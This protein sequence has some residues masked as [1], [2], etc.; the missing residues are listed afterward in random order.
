M[1]CQCKTDKQRSRCV[2]WC[3]PDE[4][5]VES[6]IIDSKRESRVTTGCHP[7]IMRRWMSDMMAM[8]RG[9]TAANEDLRNKHERNTEQLVRAAQ[10][11]HDGMSGVAE[12]ADRLRLEDHRQ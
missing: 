6:R 5:I 3:G 8:I 12:V 10:I 7:D 1:S 2:W 9:L 11:W 4:G